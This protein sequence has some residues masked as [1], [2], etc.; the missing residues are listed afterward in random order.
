[1]A[2]LYLVPEM[3]DAVA[4]GVVTVTGDEARHAITVARIRVGEHIAIGDGAGLVV[5][6]TVTSLP[7]R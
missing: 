5:E 6:G 7:R 2:S 1:M 4:G 3:Q